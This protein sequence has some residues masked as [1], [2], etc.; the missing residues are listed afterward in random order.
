VYNIERGQYNRTASNENYASTRDAYEQGRSEQYRSRKSTPIRTTCTYT[1][2]LIGV[3][4]LGLAVVAGSFAGGG[5]IV[6]RKLGSMISS[7]TSPRGEASQTAA[8]DAARP[9]APVMSGVT[10]IG[11][12]AK[13]SP[14]VDPQ[15]SSTLPPPTLF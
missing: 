2:A 13:T 11:G 12:G 15:R 8:G 9:P 14:H 7:I 10:A 1:L 6:D 5:Q 3:A 4:M